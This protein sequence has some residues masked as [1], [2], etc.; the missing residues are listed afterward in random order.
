MVAGT[1]ILVL[2]EWVSP[3][4]DSNWHDPEG[5]KMGLI[6][7]KEVGQ[8]CSLDLRTKNEERGGFSNYSV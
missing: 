6:R 3:V 2:E 1:L 8:L 7:K 5:E 4:F